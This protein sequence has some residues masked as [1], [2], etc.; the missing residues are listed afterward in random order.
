MR[1]SK[2][3]SL[4]TEMNTLRK[5]TVEFVVGDNYNIVERNGRDIDTVNSGTLDIDYDGSIVI[6]TKNG[7]VYPEISEIIPTFFNGDMHEYLNKAHVKKLCNDFIREAIELLGCMLAGKWRL[8]TTEEL[9]ADGYTSD[10]EFYSKGESYISE[11]DLEAFNCEGILK[12]DQ[13]MKLFFC[14]E[15]ECVEIDENLIRR[16]K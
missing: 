15:S 6:L 1:I 5:D 7:A 9:I 3:I 4:L 14:H 12:Y 2:L 10:G 8:A 16:V 11:N 13:D